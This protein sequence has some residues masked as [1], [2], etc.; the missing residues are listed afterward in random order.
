M[1]KVSPIEEGTRELERVTSSASSTSS[2]GSSSA[3]SVAGVP[4]SSCSAWSS[5]PFLFSSGDSSASRMSSSVG[6]VPPESSSRCGPR[7]PRMYRSRT[8]IPTISS[9]GPPAG[10]S[11]SSRTMVSRSLR[12]WTRF[13]GVSAGSSSQMA[14]KVQAEPS[15]SVRA[16]CRTASTMPRSILLKTRLSP[17]PAWG[18]GRG[19]KSRWRSK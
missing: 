11:R 8:L 19:A 9:S 12:T 7:R 16:F 15:P 4:N 5:L 3:M 1:L 6:P 14:W 18:S 2:S 17:L 10:P 13:A